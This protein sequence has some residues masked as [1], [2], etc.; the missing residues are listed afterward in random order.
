VFDLYEICL[1]ST[2]F[3]PFAL[4]YHVIKSTSVIVVRSQM[5]FH[6]FVDTPQEDEQSHSLLIEK[7]VLYIC[8]LSLCVLERS[9]I[10]YWHGRGLLVIG[11]GIK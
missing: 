4:N 9:F 10:T 7:P 5:K 1:A 3:F 8:T 6:G 2:W 11:K